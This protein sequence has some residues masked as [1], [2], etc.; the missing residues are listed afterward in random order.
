MMHT[1]NEKSKGG[2][3]VDNMQIGLKVVVELLR[4]LRSFVS[5]I[6]DFLPKRSGSK[7]SFADKASDEKDV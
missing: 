3:F 2:L 1:V 6:S 7:F 5:I 4:I